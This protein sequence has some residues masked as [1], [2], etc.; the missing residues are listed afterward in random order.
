MNKLY[1]VATPIG[2]LGDVTKRSLEILND[3]DLILAEDTRVTY[4]LLKHFNIDKEMMSY[5]KYNEKSKL[6]TII[7]ILKTKDVALVSDAGMPLISDPGYVLVKEA[8]EKGIEVISIPGASAL[9]SALSI[10]GL[11][12]SSFAFYGFLS[13]SK[14]SKELKKVLSNEISTFVIYESPKRIMKLLKK[15]DELNSDVLLCVCNDLTKM[16]ERSYYGNITDVIRELEGNPKKDKGE[17]TIVGYI[18]EEEVN[19]KPFNN[20]TYLIEEMIN[21]KCS[22]KEAIEIVSNKYGINKK[23]VYKASLELKKLFK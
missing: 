3:C 22:A 4:K 11:E 19:E 18:K 1:I 2:N 6:D 12:T 17:Y 13:H 21:N 15:I 10:S 20:E 23:D 16:H 7:N 14:L 8:R 5:H 9:T